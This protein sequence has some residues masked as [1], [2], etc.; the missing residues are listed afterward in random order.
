MGPQLDEGRDPRRV[1]TQDHGWMTGSDHVAK[2]RAAHD[3]DPNPT[4]TLHVDPSMREV[5]SPPTATAGEWWGLRS[6]R[7]AMI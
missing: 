5:G 1:A 6:P 2:H 7:F 4:D 3:A